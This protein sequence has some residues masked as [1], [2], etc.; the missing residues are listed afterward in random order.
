MMKN[1]DSKN[2]SCEVLIIG[3]GPAGSTAARYLASS[4]KDISVIV[5]EKDTFPRDKPCGGALTIRIFERFDYLSTKETESVVHGGYLYA[6]NLISKAKIEDPENAVG[7]MVLRKNFDNYLVEKA[8]ESGAKVIENA[9]IENFEI[10]DDKIIVNLLDGNQ[11]TAKILLGADGVSS[12]VAK[13]TKLNKKWKDDELGMCILAQ[14]ELDETQIQKYNPKGLC[15]HIHIAYKNLFGYFWTFYKKNH[16]NIGLGCLL[17]EKKAKKVNLKTAFK[18]YLNYLEKKEIIP[19]LES[20]NLKLQGAMVPLKKPL[21]RTFDHRVLL[22]GDS[23]GFVNPLSGEGI[24]YAM[25]SGDDAAKAIIHL[26]QLGKDYTKN[27]LKIYEKIWKA[28][29][30]NELKK[31][32]FIRRFIMASATIN[33]VITYANN[34]PKFRDLIMKFMLGMEEISRRTLGW[35]FLKHVIKDFFK[36]FKQIISFNGIMFYDMIDKLYSTTLDLITGKKTS[37][38]NTRPPSYLQDSQ[39]FVLALHDSRKISG[40]HALNLVFQTIIFKLKHFV[41]NF[42]NRIK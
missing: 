14:K 35:Y 11:I 1:S 13:K 34:D 12:I 17:S 20:L 31:I 19:S 40:K 2:L 3:A 33:N 38:F 5:L 27:N 28:D 7:Y 24:Y 32:L 8:K 4:N 26:K 22:L 21:D 37:Y 23:A 30:G 41:N 16:V 29:F 39:K 15:V 36:K 42:R 25:S 6:P 18:D 9:K 10:L